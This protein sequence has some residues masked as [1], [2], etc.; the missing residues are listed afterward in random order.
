MVI[1][2]KK[3]FLEKFLETNLRACSRNKNSANENKK[4]YLP[5]ANIFCFC[6]V[7]TF[8]VFHVKKF[9]SVEY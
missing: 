8:T 9:I 5:I 2:P 7:F 1:Q 4:S 6:I 3:A